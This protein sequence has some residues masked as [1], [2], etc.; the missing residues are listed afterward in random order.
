[1]NYYKECINY[2]VY[3]NQKYNALKKFK[4]RTFNPSKNAVYLL[5]MYQYHSNNQSLIHNF[6]SKIYYR[7][8]F[9]NYNIFVHP[10]T[11]IGKGLQLPHPSGIVFGEYALIGENCRIFQHVTIG[12]KKE[13]DWKEKL[14]PQ[15][16]NNCT[17]FAGACVLGKINIADNTTIG[18]NSIIT[19]DTE[20]NSTYA[21]LS[22]RIK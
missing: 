12:V 21:G 17:I 7:K 11:K 10:T 14:Y 1:M 20:E 3:S 18:C 8:L 9:T 16:G 2:E 13:D 22:K 19:K 4:I 6:L 5:R 15:I